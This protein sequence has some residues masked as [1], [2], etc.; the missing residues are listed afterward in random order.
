MAAASVEWVDGQ[1]LR[2]AP[3]EPSTNRPATI[4]LPLGDPG[5]PRALVHLWEVAG[6]SESFHLDPSSLK[7]WGSWAELIDQ[8]V[9]L[10]RMLDDVIVAHR[11]RVDR[12]ESQRRRKI[13]ESLAEFAAG[14]GHELNNPLAV[15]VGRAQL[16]LGRLEEDPDSVRSLR[17]II[18]QAQRAARIL[19]DL[20]FVARTPDPRPR[21]CHP[22]EVIRACLRDLQTEAETRGVKLVNEAREPGLRVLTDPESLRQLADILTR[23]ALEATP[24]GGVVHFSSGGDVRAL[25]WTVHD[26]GRG[27]S[28]H[29]GAHL[30]DPFY[31][32][33][34]AGRGLGMGLPRASRIV[35]MAGGDIK[36]HSIPGTGTTFSVTLP[37]SEIPGSPEEERPAGRGPTGP[38]LAVKQ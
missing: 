19:R 38:C 10:E 13:N 2:E 11:G 34:Q 8:R 37:V 30:F 25:R 26:S 7:A 17:A 33:R 29:E 16:L 6:L 4:T 18:T 15:I 28:T 23:N 36:W 24:S 27:L 22:E 1:P 31:C 20:M 35:Q 12:E 32:G 14:A 5:S 9:R 3:V 21:P